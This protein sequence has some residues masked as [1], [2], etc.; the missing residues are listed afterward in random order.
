MKP[1]DIESLSRHPDGDGFFCVTSK[2]VGA[3]LRVDDSLARVEVVETFTVP[4]PLESGEA[5]EA[6]GFSVV[7]LDG[8]YWA[9]W[10]DRGSDERTA[11]VFWGHFDPTTYAFQ[12]VDHAQVKVP[13]PTIS[14]LRHISELRVNGS[15]VLYI[16]SAAEGSNDGP[17]AGAFYVAGVFRYN[18]A[19]DGF[20]LHQQNPKVPLHR[21]P[22]QKIEAFD[23]VPG[24]DGGIVFATDNEHQGSSIWVNWMR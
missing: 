17:F 21:A 19:R 16:S 1:V 24:P 5:P 11:T 4:L 3:H 20:F 8:I 7:N 22:G 15:G 13:Y 10:A 6:E 18:E 14:E 2:G 9:C 23:L 12:V